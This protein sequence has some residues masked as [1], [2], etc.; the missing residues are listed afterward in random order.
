M[1]MPQEE[2]LPIR[3]PCEEFEAFVRRRLAAHRRLRDD[4]EMMRIEEALRRGLD[5]LAAAED[6]DDPD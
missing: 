6:T 5:L 3:P 4:A 1:S 2:F